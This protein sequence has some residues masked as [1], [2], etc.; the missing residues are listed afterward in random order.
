MVVDVAAGFSCVAELGVV[1]LF[2]KKI[3]SMAF[4]AFGT[5]GLLFCVYTFV[6]VFKHLVEVIFSYLALF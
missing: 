6:G 2:L 5:E 1:L 4:E 3:F